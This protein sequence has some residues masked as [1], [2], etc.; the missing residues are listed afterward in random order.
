V[1][2]EKEGKN[3]KKGENITVCKDKLMIIKRKDKKDICLMST[4]HDEKLVQTR[5]RDQDMKKPKVVV[6]YNSIMG[7]VDMGDA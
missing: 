3:I 1:P 7:E 5:V 6:D 4:T 2:D